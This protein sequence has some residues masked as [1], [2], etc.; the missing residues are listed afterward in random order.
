MS[1]SITP[2]PHPVL[3]YEPMERI[4]VGRPV[5]RIPYIVAACAGLRVLDLG[6]MDETAFHSKRG[7]GTWLHEEIGAVAAQ[8][9]GFD[10]SSLVPPEGVKTG[11]RS[12]IRKSNIM[13]LSGL[14]DV[15]GAAP[16]VVVA[17]E[18]IEHLE[19]PLAFLSSIQAEPRLQG[20]TLILSTPNATALHNGLVGL[21]GRESTHR[22][23]L[24]IFSYKTLNTL[25]QRAG[26]AAWEIVPYR[27]RFTEMRA[28]NRGWRG[29]LIGLGERVIN[30]IEWAFPLLGFG[31]VVRVLI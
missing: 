31:Y 10:S 17:G 15:L 26:F 29:A 9:D 28:R 14:L 23:H 8:V 5:D 27:S 4:R 1:E 2:A 30:A 11:P 19:N 3:R 21:I 16:D 22:D 20:R 12:S 25:C 24:S 7:R 18:L 6:A 13:D